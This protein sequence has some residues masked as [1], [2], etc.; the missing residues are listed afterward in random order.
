MVLAVKMEPGIRI[1]M[2]CLTWHRQRH[3]QQKEASVPTQKSTK[4]ATRC[5]NENSL[6]YPCLSYLPPSNIALQTQ[7]EKPRNLNP[8]QLTLPLSFTYLHIHLPHASPVRWPPGAFQCC[9]R[10]NHQADA[11]AAAMAM[12]TTTTATTPTHN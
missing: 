4:C 2:K 8:N 1:T 6:P 7:T 11:C 9:A 3:R 10:Q 12:A 5:E